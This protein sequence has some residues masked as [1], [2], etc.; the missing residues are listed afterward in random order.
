MRKEFQNAFRDFA[1]F[2]T[3]L[4]LS[5]SVQFGFLLVITVIY[6]LEEK[7]RVIEINRTFYKRRKSC[8]KHHPQTQATKPMQ[9][10]QTLRKSIL[11]VPR[12]NVLTCFDTRN[13]F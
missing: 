10:N 9:V 5:P 2:K 8:V 4:C 3:E 12:D 7:N 6:N 13:D 11:P 1:C